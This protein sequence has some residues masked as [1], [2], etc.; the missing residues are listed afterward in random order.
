ML[1]EV[2]KIEGQTVT[3]LFKFQSETPPSKDHKIMHKGEFYDVHQVWW[4]VTDP[5]EV[6]PRPGVMMAYTDKSSC[7]V[8]VFVVRT[9]R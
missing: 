4:L 5:D 6:K 9:F 3:N 2:V 8:K 1:I 7:T